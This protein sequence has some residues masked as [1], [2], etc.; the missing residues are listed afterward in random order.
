MSADLTSASG[1]LGTPGKITNL[2]RCFSFSASSE[3]ESS[4]LATP[5]PFQSPK[6][7]TLKLTYECLLTVLL[8]LESALMVSRVND[9]RIE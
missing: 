2:S 7:C 1:V 4:L 3:N 8:S 6:P 5:E 9:Q